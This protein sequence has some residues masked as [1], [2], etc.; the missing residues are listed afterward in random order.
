MPA[1]SKHRI[2]DFHGLRTTFITRLA[3][4]GVFPTAARDMARHSDVNLTMKHYTH[5]ALEDAAGA[6]AKLP[7]IPVVSAEELR[8]TGTEGGAD[9]LARGLSSEPAQSMI[10]D[11]KSG[12]EGAET[13]ENGEPADCGESANNHVISDSCMVRPAGLEP[14]TPGLGNQRTPKGAKEL[15]KVLT[16]S[17]EIL[18]VA[19]AWPALSANVRAAILE[20]VKL[21]L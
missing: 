16:T 14:A 7:K 12:Q 9:R 3:R 6:L 2:V 15:R 21:G 11:D 8:A 19:A 1:N 20:L 5:L 10:N 4:A 18:R 13:E 17:P